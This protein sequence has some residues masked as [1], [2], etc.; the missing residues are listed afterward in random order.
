MRRA[1]LLER[2]VAVAGM[3]V[4]WLLLW[5]NAGPFTIAGGIVVAVLALMMFPLPLVPF[6]GRG[7]VPG[8][9]L[10]LACFL[11]D[12]VLASVQVTWLA[13]RPGPAPASAIIAV[14]LRAGTDLHITLTAAALSLIPG[15]LIVEADRARAILYVHVIGV[16]TT[17][18]VDAQ[19]AAV[20]AL[21]SRILRATGMRPHS[22]G[23]ATV[24]PGVTESATGPADLPAADA[25]DG[26]VPDSRGAGHG[27]PAG[28][29][30]EPGRRLIADRNVQERRGPAGTGTALRTDEEDRV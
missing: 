3:V 15:S 20:R 7:S 16:S 4:V 30:P 29:E 2:A 9:V 11:R 24:L 17:E 23:G 6:G 10:F 18:D 19:R 25:P 8:I 13:I 27:G 1:T 28:G 5:G 14:P 12:L 21:E 26:R 22:R